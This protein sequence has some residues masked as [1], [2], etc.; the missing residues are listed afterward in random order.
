M[1]VVDLIQLVKMVEKPNM[2]VAEIGVYD[3]ES[4]FTY[5]DIIKKNKGKLFLIDTWMGN[6]GETQ[7]P[8]RY[9]PNTWYDVYTKLRNKIKFKGYKKITKF[10]KM[11]SN[12][13]YKLIPY[14]SL[15]LCFIDGDHGY[16][17]VMKDI[18][19]YK[20]KVKSGGI[21]AGH[22]YNIDY[23]IGQEY[24]EDVLENQGSHYGVSKAVIEVFGDKFSLLNGEGNNH[25]WYIKL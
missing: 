14:K 16:K 12:K 3:G 10:Y 5:I 19:N 6:V 18:N 24:S 8:H 17:G 11:D 20:S 25:C 4:T 13:A 2:Q 9:N 1:P 21:L 22:D 7:G 23:Q 15:D